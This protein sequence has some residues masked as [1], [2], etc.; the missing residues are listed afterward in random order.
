MIPYFV[1][2]PFRQYIYKP[3]ER[4]RRRQRLKHE[5]GVDRMKYACEID[6]WKRQ[7]EAESGDLK[8]AHY[9]KIMLAIAGESDQQFLSG[10]IVADFGCGPRGSLQWADQARIRIGIDVLS[11]AYSAFNTRDHDMCYVV[12]TEK[13]IPLPSNYVDV[14]VT[15]NAIDHVDDFGA[16]CREIRRIIVPGGT[17]LGSFNLGEPPSRTE[18]QSLTEELIRE[19]LLRH[20]EVISYR[21]APK[22]KRDTYKFLLEDNALQDDESATD[23]QVLWVRATLTDE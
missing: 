20:M 19:H 15:L 1:Q 16:L 17:F 22:G 14:L 7:F 2:R 8:H 10:K 6:F 3:Y 12:S 23:H 11:D 21:V 18:P 9:E 4:F 13:W 5:F